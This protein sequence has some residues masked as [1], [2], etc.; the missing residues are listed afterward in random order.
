MQWYSQR[1][2]L[3]VHLDYMIKLMQILI[4]L[5]LGHHRVNESSMLFGI[6]YF[7]CMDPK[8]SVANF[9]Y[10]HVH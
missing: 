10:M 7:L 6:K 4:E 5:N 9:P 3:I 2:K 8:Y 1:L